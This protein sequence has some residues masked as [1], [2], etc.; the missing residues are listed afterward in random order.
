MTE[1]TNDHLT[2]E[3]RMAELNTTAGRVG[4]K[5]EEIA[6]WDG[7]WEP[8]EDG[9]KAETR[10]FELTIKEIEALKRAS[11]TK[12]RRHFEKNGFCPSYMKYNYLNQK[13]GGNEL[14][15]HYDDPKYLL[16]QREE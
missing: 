4:D 7:T 2:F 5:L 1:D 6:D 8:P 9:R 16:M 10:T 3:Q 11:R 12:A 15:W 13:F 14:Q